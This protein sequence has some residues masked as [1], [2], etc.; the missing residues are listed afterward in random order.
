MNA[1]QIIDIAADEDAA[2]LGFRHTLAH[3]HVA[4]KVVAE[5]SDPN[6]R[7]DLRIQLVDIRTDKDAVIGYLNGD[8]PTDLLALRTWKLSNR[9][10]LIELDAAGK[11]LKDQA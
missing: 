3:A 4:A 2:L 7:G 10:G 8:K 1:Y 11:P 6:V 5:K 9:G